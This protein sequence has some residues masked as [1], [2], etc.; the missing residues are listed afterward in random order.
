MCSQIDFLTCSPLHGD[1]I[2][3]VHK[4]EVH[5]GSSRNVT[6]THLHMNAPVRINDTH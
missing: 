2:D 5:L 6:Y 4:C 3:K 1:D